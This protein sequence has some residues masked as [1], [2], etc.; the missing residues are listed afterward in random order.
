VIA[1]L[2][3]AA[4]LAGVLDAA[5][6]PPP[7]SA[8]P[9][10]IALLVGI[11]QYDDPE[12]GDLRFA[13]QDAV[14]LAEVLADPD[15]GAFDTVRVLSGEVTAPQIWEALDGITAYLRRDDTFLLYI[16]GHGTLSLE[17]GTELFVMS[18]E[19][20]LDRIRASGVPV[21]ALQQRITALPSRRRALV[22]DTC[23]SGT[24]RSV[25][26]QDAERT[27]AQVRGPLPAPTALAVSQSEV[28]LYS[29]H[30]NQPALEDGELGNGVYTHFLI[31][32]LRGA[33][34][35][36]GDG[37]VEAAEAHDFARDHTL[38]HTGGVQVPWMETQV[39]GREEVFL[40][41][42]P[43]E[44]ARAERALLVGLARLPSESRIGVDGTAR[45][46]AGLEPGRHR[47]TVE[48]DAGVMLDQGVRVRRGQELD[49]ARLVDS[50]R[51]TWWIEGGGAWTADN[52]W[53][54]PAGPQGGI[55]WTPADKGGG[56]LA[57]GAQG[58]MGIGASPTGQVLARAG[59]WW[60][61]QLVAGP[62]VDAGLFWR[63]LDGE[64]QGAPIV[65][66]GG[67]LRYTWGPMQL[68]TTASA[69]VFSAQDDSLTLPRVG[70][71]V[72]W[73]P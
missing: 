23:H 44:R 24:G 66:P 25:L 15:G 71:A 48:T 65:A 54:A 55:W 21:D 63:L 30:F 27:L 19:S 70:V 60:G 1:A 72:G 20:S 45:G 28:R 42:R 47:L 51:S 53:T 73:S 16:A 37:L 62:V 5:P 41:G 64:R 46:A 68:S 9:R 67:T 43:D 57:L 22:L 14:D 36:D 34:D 6:P 59:W 33:G 7:Q 56:R 11:D 58:T 31:E 10:R 26:S 8:A 38:S 32:A 13:A 40:A 2:V 29:A 69:L 18:S 4:A 61:Q 49:V 50:R 52:E 12:L 3:S 17:R 39:V 35:L